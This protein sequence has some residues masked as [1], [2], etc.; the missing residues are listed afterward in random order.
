MVCNK[1]LIAE[2]HN[3]NCYQMTIMEFKAI[4]P[5]VTPEE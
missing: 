1:V 2:N 3:N 4:S 5:I